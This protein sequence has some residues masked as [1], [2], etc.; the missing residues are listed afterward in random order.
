MGSWLMS[1]VIMY[2]L[3]DIFLKVNERTHLG[4]TRCTYKWTNYPVLN[5]LRAEMTTG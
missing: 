2:A 4:F 5:D 1:L 3:L